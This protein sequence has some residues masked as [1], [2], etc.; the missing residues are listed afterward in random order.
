MQR[1]K[2]SK[3]MED[4]NNSMNQLDLIDIYPVPHIITVKHTFFQVQVEHSCLRQNKSQ[5]ISKS[6]P[7][8]EGEMRVRVSYMFC[9][10]WF[11]E[12]YSD[13]TNSLAASSW[14]SNVTYSLGFQRSY[15][16]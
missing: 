14:S 2:I 1:T 9:N 13:I 6:N 16:D 8:Q 3:D 7:V 12:C 10:L 11:H 5:Y 15:Q 4:L